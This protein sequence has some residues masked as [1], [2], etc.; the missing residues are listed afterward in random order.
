[1]VLVENKEF[2]FGIVNSIRDSSALC[3]CRKDVTFSHYNWN[4]ELLVN[5]CVETLCTK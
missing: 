1:M 3:V 2:P 4:V 5:Q